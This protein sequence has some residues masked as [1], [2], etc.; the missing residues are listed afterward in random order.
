MANKPV[1]YTANTNIPQGSNADVWKHNWAVMKPFVR[2][3]FKAMTLIGGALIGIVK[4]LPSLL[5]E[6]KE[7]PKKSD[8]VIKI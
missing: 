6:H 1:K 3:G 2:F 4:L 5:A 7:Q 8:K